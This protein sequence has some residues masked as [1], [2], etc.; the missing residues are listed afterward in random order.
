M[1]FSIDNSLFINF[2]YFNSPYIDIYDNHINKNDIINS[3]K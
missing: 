1:K 3:K 2:Y